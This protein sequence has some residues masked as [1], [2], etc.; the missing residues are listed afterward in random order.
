MW[1]CCRPNDNRPC[2]AMTGLVPDSPLSSMCLCGWH[3]VPRL[4]TA[5][6]CSGT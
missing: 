1:Y 6:V 3:M 5:H 2:I 4:P